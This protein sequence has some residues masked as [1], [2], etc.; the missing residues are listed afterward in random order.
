[1]NQMKLLNSSRLL[2]GQPAPHL[3]VNTLG[4][5]FW[6]LDQQ[7]PENYTMIV[8]YRGAHCPVCQQYLTGLE[9]RLEAFKQLGIEVIAISG[10]TLG[11]A[12]LTQNRSK[13]QQL[14]LGFG[15]SEDSMREWGLYLSK[16]SFEQEPAIFS[17]PAVFLIKPDGQLYLANIGTHPFSR[18]DF[19]FL[20]Q[21]LEYVIANNYPF[22]GTE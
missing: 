2:M 4:G 3:E 18:I 9:G 20:L 5:S 12:A 13:L 14:R 21:G 15:L 7:T 17:E 11:K 1:M 19:D 10:D 16:G 22:R 8:F 6:I